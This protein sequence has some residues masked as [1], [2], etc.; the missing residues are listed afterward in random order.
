MAKLDGMIELCLVYFKTL[1]VHVKLSF[2]KAS[3][4]D[5]LKQI[6]P[7][8]RWILRNPNFFISMNLV[9]TL[10]KIMGSSLYKCESGGNVAQMV[11]ALAA[12][13]FSAKLE[14]AHRF[15]A[16]KQLLKVFAQVLFKRQ[17][18]GTEGNLR[19]WVHLPSPFAYLQ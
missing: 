1:R 10:A 8:F 7:L 2:V 6:L 12:C 18:H 17:E 3:Y 15:W 19:W 14:A 16:L 9:Q 13:L 11:D 5:T 4:L